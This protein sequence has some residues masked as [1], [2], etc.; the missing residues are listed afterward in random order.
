MCLGDSSVSYTDDGHSGWSRHPTWPYTTHNVA[1]DGPYEDK[2]DNYAPPG[3]FTGNVRYAAVLLPANFGMV[4]GTLGIYYSY[5]NYRK[6]FAVSA[7]AYVSCWTDNANYKTE[8]NL[9]AQVPAGF[10]YPNYR[11]IGPITKYGSFSRSTSRS[12][13]KDGWDHEISTNPNGQASA[14][15]T[16]PSDGTTHNTSAFTPT[17]GSA[18]E[19]TINCGFCDDSGCDVC[20][21]HR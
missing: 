13:D 18:N 17:P 5:K 12:G 3:F 4:P 14:S 21:P 7:D 15:G 9:Y 2:Y 19:L 16:N 20:N 11:K 1:K 6:K 10:Q 8:Y